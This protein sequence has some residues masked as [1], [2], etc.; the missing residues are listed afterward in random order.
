[1]RRRIA[2][3]L[4]RVAGG[5][6]TRLFRAS[7]GRIGGHMFG[8]PV[9]LLTVRGR[10]SGKPRGTPLLYLRDGD[11]YVVVASNGGM[12][13]PEWWRNLR[14]SPNGLIE[15]RDG[16]FRVRAEQADPDERARLWPLVNQM[17]GGYDGYQQRAGWEIPVVK[18]HPAGDWR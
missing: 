8:G 17:Y 7:R 3:S 16:R 5:V 18:L 1:M 9:L 4:G 15:T 11:D 6:H 2:R 14:A 13:L 12:A 10:K